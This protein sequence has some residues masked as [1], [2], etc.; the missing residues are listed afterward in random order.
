MKTKILTRLQW[1][2]QKKKKKKERKKNHINKT[3]N[4]KEEITT[5][6]AEIQRIVRYYYEY[7]YGFKL[8]NLEEM[9]RVLKKFKHPRLNQEEIEIVTKP[10]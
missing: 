3:R 8:D 7:L 4:E 5:E 10:I 6:N 9:N 2:H 1:T